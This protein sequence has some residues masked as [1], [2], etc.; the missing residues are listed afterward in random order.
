MSL[1]RS[2]TYVPGLYPPPPNL[3][4]TRRRPVQSGPPLVNASVMSSPSPLVFAP[5]H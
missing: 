5:R 1:D 2:V 3:C 4:C